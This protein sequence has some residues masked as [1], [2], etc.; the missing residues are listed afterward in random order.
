MPLVPSLLLLLA[1]GYTPKTPLTLLVLV[2]G[3]VLLSR[4]ATALGMARAAAR[5]AQ[6]RP[7]Y[8]AVV[9]ER[10]PDA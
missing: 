5:Q 6:A 4:A 10:P 3:V 8:P 9:L 1:A 2:L 7:A